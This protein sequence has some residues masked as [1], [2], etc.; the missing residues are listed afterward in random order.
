MGK[1]K[2]THEQLVSDLVGNDDGSLSLTLPVDHQ[3][4]TSHGYAYGEGNTTHVLLTRCHIAAIDTQFYCVYRMHNYK[5][6]H[7]VVRHYG[8]FNYAKTREQADQM[9][10]DLCRIEAGHFAGPAGADLGIK[11]ADGARAVTRVTPDW[12]LEAE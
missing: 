1:V 3:V 10:E 12:E 8:A 4:I 5:G 9:F 2:A 6:L 11:V 7:A